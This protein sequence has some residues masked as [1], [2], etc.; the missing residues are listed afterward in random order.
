[1]TERTRALGRR[2]KN[3]KEKT[4]EEIGKVNQMTALIFQ[5]G[6]R[7]QISPASLRGTAA[8]AMSPQPSTSPTAAMSPQPSPSP[9]AAAIS[10]Q[11]S[12]SPTAAAMSPQPSASPT[13]AA[14]SPTTATSPTAA[15]TSSARE[16]MHHEERQRFLSS[17]REP[18][19]WE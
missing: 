10:P 16:Q 12:T 3:K 14:I 15:A 9:T 6:G 2:R 7:H 19:G 11:S 1:M 5:T 13:A 4:R 18:G 8:G 17:G